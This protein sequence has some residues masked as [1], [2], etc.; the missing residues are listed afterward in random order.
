M[1]TLTERPSTNA[2]MGPHGRSLPTAR[3]IRSNPGPHELQEL[4]ARLPSARMVD[5]QAIVFT[6]NTS[7]RGPTSLLVEWDT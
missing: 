2:P 3:S 6:R 1:S 5:D 7:F 4:T